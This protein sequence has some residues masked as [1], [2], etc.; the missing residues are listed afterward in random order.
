MR[1]RVRTYKQQR[2]VFLVEF[3]FVMPIILFILFGGFEMARYIRAHQV[4]NKIAYE[5]ARGLLMCVN[6]TEGMHPVVD[7]DAI[8]FQNLRT[9]ACMTAYLDRYGN[10]AS[11]FVNGSAVVVNANIVYY[12][13][14]GTALADYSGG[15]KVDR[16][17]AVIPSCGGVDVTAGQDVNDER[18]CELG[19]EDLKGQKSGPGL[20]NLRGA[21]GLARDA[22][23]GVVPNLTGVGIYTQVVVTHDSLIQ[24][25]LG[26]RILDWDNQG[27][28]NYVASSAF[29]H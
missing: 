4:T 18:Y 10:M 8:N 17:G 29:V 3:A 24:A 16:H 27:T 7:V 22:N 9:K 26:F 19:D 12:D 25:I 6:P 20:Q 5:L 28:I 11:G 15:H 23:G 1:K 13:D 21:T 2:G 14:V